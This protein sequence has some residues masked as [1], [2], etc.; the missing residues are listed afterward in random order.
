HPSSQPTSQPPSRQTQY[1]LPSRYIHLPPSATES[2]RALPKSATI[3]PQPRPAPA[4]RS[5]IACSRCRRSKVKCVNS[6]INTTCRACEASGREC[7]YPTP[8]VGANTSSAAGGDGARKPRPK[9]NPVGPV[10]G[11]LKPAGHHGGL[12]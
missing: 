1:T 3:D 4:M 9:K 6:G 8:V 2:Q 7:T 10:Q 11:S 5:S 12:S